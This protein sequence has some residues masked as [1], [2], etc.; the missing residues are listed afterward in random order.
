MIKKWDAAETEEYLTQYGSKEDKKSGLV[1]KSS[2]SEIPSGWAWG[3]GGKIRGVNQSIQADDLVWGPFKLVLIGYGNKNLQKQG[4]VKGDTFGAV[5]LEEQLT[6]FDD[7]C[8]ANRQSCF[9]QDRN[10]FS[11]ID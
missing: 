4:G 1:A 11:L 6:S 8:L 2:R 10:Q 5:C 7:M 3:G 9:Q